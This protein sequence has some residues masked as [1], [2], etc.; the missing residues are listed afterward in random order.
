MTYRLNETV[1]LF[2]NTQPPVT[3]TL[4]VTRP[5]GTA[6]TPQLGGTAGAQTGRVEADAAG[7]WTYLW[8]AP[9]AG[10]Q[11][12][13]FD[14]GP[15]DPVWTPTVEQVERQVPTR[16]P[17]DDSS[18]PTAT[19]IADLATSLAR[20]LLLDLGD[21]RALG[22]TQLAVAR[23][24]VEHATAA[25]IEWNWYPEQQ[26]GDGAG[27]QHDVWAAAELARLRVSLGLPPTTS[28]ADGD[29]SVI[30]PPQGEFPPPTPYPSPI[31]GFGAP[32]DYVVGWVV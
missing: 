26:D 20:G 23:S 28:Q 2:F 1:E 21:D 11:A 7:T 32:T 8:E 13:T 30:A 31:F 6:A 5:D 22:P 17:F 12:G 29:S 25:R 10:Q 4:L 18:R 19:Q 14:V 3:G 24:Y 15:S 16:G 9:N 27:K